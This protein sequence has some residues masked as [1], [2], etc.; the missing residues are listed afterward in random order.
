MC[1]SHTEEKKGHSSCK[2]PYR[3]ELGHDTDGMNMIWQFIY[4]VGNLDK[5]INISVCQSSHE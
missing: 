4:T 2:D 5:F 1:S 3:E